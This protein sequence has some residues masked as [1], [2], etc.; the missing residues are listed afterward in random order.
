ME[1]FSSLVAETGFHTHQTKGRGCIFPPGR[2]SELILMLHCRSQVLKDFLIVLHHF[3]PWCLVSEMTLCS[4]VTNA[5]HHIW[6]G[7]KSFVRYITSKYKLCT[8]HMS[9]AANH[10]CH[11][12]ALFDFNLNE[13][14]IWFYRLESKK[15]CVA[16]Q[17]YTEYFVK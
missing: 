4:N 10:V 3:D 16:S 15:C 6:Q 1:P 2:S 12:K 11:D 8:S 7:F 17:L 14:L 13:L 5:H 9:D